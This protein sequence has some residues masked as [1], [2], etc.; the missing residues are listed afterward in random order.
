MRNIR[1]RIA[2][3][4]VGVLAASSWFTTS[5]GIAEAA[6]T[7]QGLYVYDWPT[8]VC[9]TICYWAANV[10]LYSNTEVFFNNGTYMR[11]AYLDHYYGHIY[12]GNANGMG[13]LPYSHHSNAGGSDYERYGS[14]NFS[15]FGQGD[16]FSCRQSDLYQDWLEYV[17]PSNHFIRGKFMVY[18]TDPMVAPNLN[19]PEY[20]VM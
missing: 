4:L 2:A 15:C 12:N 20:G 6:S 7:Q 9:G 11:E 8:L 1:R 3:G 18:S 16:F 19:R 5:G 10:D 17:P 14:S 13:I